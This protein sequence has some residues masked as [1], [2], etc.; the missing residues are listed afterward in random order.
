MDANSQSAEAVCQ[1]RRLYIKGVSGGGTY[2]V[3]WTGW[4]L[5]EREREKRG[6]EREKRMI[7]THVSGKVSEVTPLNK[8]E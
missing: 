4:C 5:R 6:K 1:H 2:H 8:R 3:H 7:R